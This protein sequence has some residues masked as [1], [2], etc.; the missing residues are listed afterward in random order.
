MEHV[1]QAYFDKHGGGCGDVTPDD[2]HSPEAVA[3]RTLSTEQV[4]ALIYLLLY[5]DIWEIP[6]DEDTLGDLATPRL[7]DD[8]MNRR[9]A[10]EDEVSYQLVAALVY[11]SGRSAS[12]FAMLY[13]GKD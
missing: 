3:L 7:M 13:P 1:N 10:E 12:E 2:M 4:N 9:L 6:L 8:L 5:G 11:L